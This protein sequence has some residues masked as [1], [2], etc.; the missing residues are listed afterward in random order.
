MNKS[1][2]R[3]LAALT[4]LTFYDLTTMASA[5]EAMN[6]VL[7]I[8][9]ISVQVITNDSKLFLIFLALTIGR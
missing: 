4:Q 3:M 1:M 5:N 8:K 9:L 2:S 7:P 6:L